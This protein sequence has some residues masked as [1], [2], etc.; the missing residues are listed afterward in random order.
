MYTVKYYNI[1]IYKN[2]VKTSIPFIG[3]LD[4]IQRISWKN[5]LRRIKE[6]PIAMF[7]YK[8]MSHEHKTKRIVPIGRF[9]RDYKPFLGNVNTSDLE[10]IEKGK[11]VVEVTTMLYCNTFKTAGIVS[12]RESANIQELE[13][14]FSSFLPKLHNIE[15]QVKFEPIYYTSNIKDIYTTPEIRGI[16]IYLKIG[17]HLQIEKS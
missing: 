6:S 13:M 2:D 5:R 7:P 10:E 8:N 12:N 16:E 11:D 9:R 15:Y 17:K 14:Y 1:A 3:I 4:N